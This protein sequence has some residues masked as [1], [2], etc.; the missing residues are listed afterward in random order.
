M[1]YHISDKCIEAMN[2]LSETNHYRGMMQIVEQ[3]GDGSPIVSAA[4]N[5]EAEQ[6][7]IITEQR[8]II[9]DYYGNIINK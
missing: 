3:H 6:Y 4:W 1:Y 5:D 7:A 2:V 8:I 9:A